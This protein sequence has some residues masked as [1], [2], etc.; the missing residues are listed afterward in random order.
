MKNF[1]RRSSSGHHG[2]E[3]REQL[4]QHA[5]SRGS[6]AFT[7]TLPSV[8][9]QPRCAKAPAQLLLFSAYWDFSCLEIHRTLTWTRIFI[10]IILVR[11]YIYTGVGHTEERASTTFL[12]RKNSQMFLMLLNLGPLG[13]ESDDD[14]LSDEYIHRKAVI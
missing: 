4:A 5:H 7:H 1:N 11:A 14:N 3:H 12:T 13:L 9:L 6:H 8:Q 2:S 10:V